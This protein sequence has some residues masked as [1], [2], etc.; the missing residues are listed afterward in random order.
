MKYAWIDGQRKDYE[1]AE[2]CATL[3]VSPSGYAAWKRGGSSF[4]QRL[5]DTQM[6]VHIQAIH[7]EVKGS[8]GSPRMTKELRGRGFPASKGRVERL[9]RE[10]GITSTIS[11]SI[12]R[13]GWRDADR[14]AATHRPDNH[15]DRF[16]EVGRSR[17]GSA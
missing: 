1:L 11:A 8:Y 14:P 9:M 13:H 2:L 17:S 12:P 6:L 7:K 3:N 16:D 10:N 5:T 15:K 4:R